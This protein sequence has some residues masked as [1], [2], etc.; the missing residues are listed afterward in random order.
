MTADDRGRTFEKLAR[1]SADSA[2]A[3]ISQAMV[4]KKKRLLIGA[5]ARYLSLISRLL[6][7]NYPRLL[8]NLG[9]LADGGQ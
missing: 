6:P 5:D 9:R 1:T 3:Q 8:P 7:A 2:A 4:K